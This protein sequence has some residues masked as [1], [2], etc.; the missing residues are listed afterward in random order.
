MRFAHINQKTEWSLEMISINL[1]VTL[2][3]KHRARGI[4]ATLASLLL[5][6]SAFAQGDSSLWGKVTDASNAPVPGATIL[7]KNLET[8]TERKLVTDDAGLFNAAALPVGQY[9]ITAAKTGF[10]TERGRAIRLTVGER[11]EIDLKL[12]VGDVHQTIEVPAFSTAVQISTEDSSGLVGEREVKDLPLNG[13]SF[14][15][16]L[17]LN[18]GIVNYT[19]QRSGGIGTSNSVVGN[20]FAVSGRRPQ[21]NLFLLNGVEYTSASE[22]NNTPGGVSGQLLGVDAV[23]EF[24]VVT[25]TYGAEYGKRP[26]AQINIVTANGTN[27]FHGSVYEFLRNSIF[28]ARNFFDHGGIP[29]FERNVFGGSA[30]GPIVRDKTFV[31][32][33]YEGYRQ[34]LGLSDLT[35]VPDNT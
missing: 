22:I 27:A 4:F 29:H 8:D 28:D 30:G 35:L 31:F 10:Q 17:T 20:M 1:A 11:E 33:N 34:S 23:R 26:G 9:E 21:E 13:R 16:L 14:D 25:D 19:S 32:G 2:A 18:P 7:I 12:Q 5:A 6:F 3:K 24:A 15:Q